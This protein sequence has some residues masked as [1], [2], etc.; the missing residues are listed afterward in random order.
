MDVI[1]SQTDRNPWDIQDYELSEAYKFFSTYYLPLKPPRTLR[2][3]Y[4][5]MLIV[6]QGF[7]SAKARQTEMT[8]E[9]LAWAFSLDAHGN[10][11]PDT[12]TWHERAVLYDDARYSD[13]KDQLKGTQLDTIVGEI[14]DISVI[15]GQ[16]KVLYDEFLLWTKHAREQAKLAGIPY[17]PDK[18]I[19]RIKELVEI[20]ERIAQFS[21]RAVG[22]PVK[23]NEIPQS[24]KEDLF[25]V[26]WN[27]PNRQLPNPK[28][29]KDVDEI[30]QILRE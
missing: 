1:Y 17:N 23:Y 3:A 9:L 29:T 10:K 21:R 26:E 5:K 28:T 22:L 25:K 24:D 16:W 4:E 11:Y 15:E 12:L 18:E 20:R 7:S 27:E 6:E 2:Q 14:Q 30:I 13:Y 19:N 8:P